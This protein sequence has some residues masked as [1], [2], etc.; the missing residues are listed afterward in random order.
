VVGRLAALYHRVGRR[1]FGSRFDV[2][3]QYVRFATIGAVG[4]IL[5]TGILYGLTE[6]GGVYYMVSAV[7]SYESTLLFAFFLNN[8]V[9]FEETKRGVRELLDGVV[10]SHLVRAAGIGVS[11]GLLYVLTD[12]AGLFYVASN[13][14]ALFVGSLVNYAGEKTFNWGES[15]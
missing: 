15:F 3:A 6:F 4:A 14:V 13:V 1:I 10:R 8:I 7:V 2:V 11:L 5:N 9:T 12:L